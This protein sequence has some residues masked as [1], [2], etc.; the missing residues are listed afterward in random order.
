M[1][2]A[3]A[4]VQSSLA[5]F[6]ELGREFPIVMIAHVVVPGLGDAERAEAPL[7]AD[8]EQGYADL[9]QVVEPGQAVAIKRI[10]I[11]L[12]TDGVTPPDPDDADTGPN[13]L[14]NQPLIL[15]AES[16][17]GSAWVSGV[18]DSGSG[19]FVHDVYAGGS[20]DPTGWGEGLEH[21]A[22]FETC[23]YLEKKGWQITFVP[24]EPIWLVK[25]SNGEIKVAV[26][27]NISPRN[28]RG[29]ISLTR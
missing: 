4:T 9:G 29:S 7:G 19:F 13:H 24:V 22:V 14:M 11:D 18:R 28:I 2:Y 23:H 26:A 8:V 12:G 6:E 10:G 5:V 16:C 27:I 1:G 3:A 17:G 15:W 25:I 20:C 21:H